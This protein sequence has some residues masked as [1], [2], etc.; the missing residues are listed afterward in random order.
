MHR[1]SATRRMEA[2][3][4]KMCLPFGSWKAVQYHSAQAIGLSDTITQYFHHYFVRNEHTS[5]Q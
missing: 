2:I 5:L 4:E 1:S 3:V